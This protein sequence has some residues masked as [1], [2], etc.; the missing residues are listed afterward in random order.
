MDHRAAGLN[1]R[2]VPALSAE[3]RSLVLSSRPSGF[4]ER[5]EPRAIGRHFSA[6]GSRRNAYIHSHQKRLLDIVV[7][8]AVLLAVAP[9]LLVLAL[10][11]KFSSAGPVIF[12]QKRN[13]KGSRYFYIYKFRTMYDRPD[14]GSI[15]FLKQA[16]PGDSRVTR[17][18]YWLRRLSLDELPQI[19]N[20]LQGKMSLV[21]PRPHAISHDQHFSKR[22]TNYMMRYE[23]N[24]GITGLAQVSGSR[25]RTESDADMQRR[26]NFDLEYIEKA[27]LL[28]DMKIILRTA[29][30]LINSKN[31]Y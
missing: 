28:F 6:A 15:G 30:H 31:V 5:A 25:G 23:C 19:L 7:S 14:E 29:I 3:H 12:K 18:G 16:R 13:G 9:V 21:G 26:V 8:L 4:S 24:P 22:L 2:I 10:T 11:V 1:D 27:S 20:V 17:L